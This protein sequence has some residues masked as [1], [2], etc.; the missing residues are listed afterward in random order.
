MTRKVF[1]SWAIIN[2]YIGKYCSSVR[3]FLSAR[4]LIVSNMSHCTTHLQP[5]CFL[6]LDG[7]IWPDS[8]TN[9]LFRNPIL[10]TET[11]ICL[12]RLKEKFPIII[13]I[14][15]QASIARGEIGRR[16]AIR[17]LK[18]LVH[19]DDFFKM[20]NVIMICPHHINSNLWRYRKHCEFRKPNPGAILRC[21]NNLM[22][23]N[24]NSVFIG[25]RITDAEAASRAG[26]KTIFL[27]HN[28]RIFERNVPNSNYSGLISFKLVKSLCDAM[29]QMK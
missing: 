28:E 4:D 8:R 15:N 13:V 20:V 7:V 21:F 2:R 16:S 27:V 10:S 26:V 11:L 22:I 9:S 29:E 17:K 1:T 25:D 24:R 3:D 23:D 18:Y 12:Q 6:D 5:V 14:S 19:N